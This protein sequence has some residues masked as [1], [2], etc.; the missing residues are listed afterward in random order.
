MSE[1]PLRRV[2]SGEEC[3]DPSGNPAP[4]D[5]YDETVRAHGPQP[6]KN[7]RNPPSWTG[8]SDSTVV[9]QFDTT[10]RPA[11]TP[12]GMLGGRNLAEAREIASQ[13]L[14]SLI[15]GINPNYFASRDRLYFLRFE[16]RPLLSS[17]YTATVVSRYGRKSPG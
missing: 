17:P 1:F 3:F 12:D 10:N 2:W 9:G 14:M 5:A 8:Q 4:L 13:S 16:W 11:T 6:T 15:G 7:A